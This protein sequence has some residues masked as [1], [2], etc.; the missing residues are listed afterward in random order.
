MCLKLTNQDRET[1]ISLKRLMLML[2]HSVVNNSVQ[3]NGDAEPRQL[4]TA[5]V[6]TAN[7]SGSE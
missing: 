2:P 7:G 4:W 5:L 3:E 1:I 6:L